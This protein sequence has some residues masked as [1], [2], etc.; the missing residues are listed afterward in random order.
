MDN[1]LKNIEA[2]GK[3]CYNN[4]TISI[5][6]GF[7]Y[8][9][10]CP[11]DNWWNS[12]K[13]V[14]YHFLFRGR[15]DKLSL[16]Y[17]NLY[18]EA[19]QSLLKFGTEKEPDFSIV[20]RLLEDFDF[21]GQ[22][23]LITKSNLNPKNDSIQQNQFA[24]FLDD[25]IKS[26]HNLN[27]QGSPKINPVDL[28]MLICL[29]FTSIQLNK[30]INNP[31]IY[32]FLI[33]NVPIR[34]KTMKVLLMKIIGVGD[35]L[36]SFLLRDI[37]ILN[38][39]KI[40]QKYYQFLF[41]VDTWVVQVYSKIKKSHDVTSSSNVIR[42][43]LLATCNKL[44]LN[45]IFVNLGCWWIGFNSYQSI[46]SILSKIDFVGTIDTVVRIGEIKR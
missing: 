16:K 1:L 35:K 20:T 27:N 24:G 32:T 4:L 6:S 7:H 45:P 12:F 25:Y 44:E 42:D 43:D 19:L 34:L 38:G 3:Y 46:L 15:K 5:L 22:I 26:Y 14:F 2:V 41:P 31:N 21:E 36:S 9:E 17:Y 40:E 10:N 18:I 39:K 23:K 11:H 29:L 28:K 37:A 13:F 8:E 30:K 33:K